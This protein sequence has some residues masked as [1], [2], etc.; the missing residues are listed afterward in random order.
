MKI[1]LFLLISTCLYACTFTPK[2]NISGVLTGVE[3]DTILVRNLPYD[4]PNEQHIDTI[5]MQKGTFSYHT[6]DSVVKKIIISP[7]ITMQ[8]GK[9]FA[10]I[11]PLEIIL[12]PGDAVRIKGTINNSK[13]SGSDFYEAYNEFFA[14]C[15]VEQTKID[16]LLKSCYQIPKEKLSEQKIRNIY[17]SVQI[18]TETIWQKKMQYITMH[19]DENLSVYLL[20]QLPGKEK[21]KMLDVLSSR[22]RQGVMAPIY[23]FAEKQYK[24]WE[25][26]S[27]A[28]KTI[29]P[30]KPAPL[31]IL[32][33][34]TG[35][36][37]SLSSLQ[38][39][40]VVLDFWGSWCGWCIKGIPN[41]KKMY[42][43]YK[44]KLEIVSIACK[45]TKSKWTEAVRKHQLSWINV[46]DTPSENIAQH[47]AI[48]GYPTKIIID[49]KGNICKIIVGET[50]EF[51]E[52]IDSLF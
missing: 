39:K 36:C 28:E 7:K 21:G 10:L 23:R 27:L 40:Y 34:I 4:N 33:D 8:V 52:Y 22:V 51:Y 49:P 1:F 29:Q 47:Y 14:S 20:T 26:H 3:S 50:T 48:E 45:D 31:F 46:L 19:P 15:S 12:L 37:F 9:P 35:K 41:M 25:L 16:S 43:K 38:G 6:V 42:N 18:Y 32:P 30:G 2:S 44:G 5:A 11:K 24:D 13:I 17:D